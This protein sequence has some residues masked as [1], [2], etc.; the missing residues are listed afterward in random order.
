MAYP[1]EEMLVPD[2]IERAM[3]LFETFR[4]RNRCMVLKAYKALTSALPARTA[5]RRD[6]KFPDRGPAEGWR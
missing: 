2:M 5:F 1:I 3:G 4:H 6:L